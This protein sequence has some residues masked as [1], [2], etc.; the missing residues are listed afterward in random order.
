[1]VF[2]VRL[3]FAPLTKWFLY[4]ILSYMKLHTSCILS[5]VANVSV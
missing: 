5:F 3:P 1:M 4:D 2:K